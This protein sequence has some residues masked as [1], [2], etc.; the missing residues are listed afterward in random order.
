ML[1]I[2]PIKKNQKN[3]NINDNYNNSYENISINH[4]I[5]SKK[6][7]YIKKKKSIIKITK[8]LRK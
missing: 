5:N 1:I 8:I 4:L 7:L 3:N 2:I 6:K